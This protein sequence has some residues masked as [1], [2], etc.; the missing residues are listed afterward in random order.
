MEQTRGGPPVNRHAHGLDDLHFD[1]SAPEDPRQPEPGVPGL[2]GGG[3]SLHGGPR[4]GRAL[5]QPRDRGEQR[6]RPRLEALL[7]LGSL[8][9]RDMGGDDPGGLRDLHRDHER[10]PQIWQQSRRSRHGTASRTRNTGPA[11]LAGTPA[12]LI[13][14]VRGI[15]EDAATVITGPAHGSY[16][17]QEV[18]IF[19]GGA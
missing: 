1:A 14:S 2:V 5:P 15:A 9:T 8:Q 3:G 4:F 11:M 6:V 19:D 17:P 18:V 12:R 7:D 13:G 10:G 16:P